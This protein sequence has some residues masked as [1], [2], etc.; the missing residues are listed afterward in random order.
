[1][2]TTKKEVIAWLK[3]NADQRGID[4]WKK[5]PQVL[6]TVGIGLT[7]LRKYAKQ[8][9]RDHALAQSLWKS[10]IYEAKVLALLVDDPKKITRE[11]AESQVDGGLNSGYLAHVFASCDATLAKTPF[12]FELAKDWV[13]SKDAMRRRCGYALLYELSKKNPK[14]MDDDY[15]LERIRHIRETIH[16]EEKW[17]RESMNTALMGIGK[18]NALLNAAAIEAA[19]AIGPVDI[20]YGDDNDCQPLDVLKHLRSDYLQKKLFG[21]AK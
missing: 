9:G 3:E 4:H 6:K 7:R 12:A 15:L 14:G 10:D 1:M 11:Q 19:E 16:D 18:R 13:Q 17:V 20:D 2:P 21:T 8:I 5:R